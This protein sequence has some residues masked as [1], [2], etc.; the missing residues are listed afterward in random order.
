MSTELMMLKL[1]YP[2]SEVY[3]KSLDCI[4][5]ALGEPDMYIESKNKLVIR[6]GHNGRYY[7]IRIYC[8]SDNTLTYICHGAHCRNLNFVIRAMTGNLCQLN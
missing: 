5:N 1:K 8:E 3:L 6:Y 7:D 2:V 4:V